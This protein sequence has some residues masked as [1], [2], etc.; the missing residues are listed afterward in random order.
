[1]KPKFKVEYTDEQLAYF[2]ECGRKGH[3]ARLK[4]YGKKKV[5]EMLQGAA[6]KM[7]EKKYKLNN[8]I[9]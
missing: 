6:R 5:R 1:M 4:K 8:K 7:N 2:R 9:K 3:A